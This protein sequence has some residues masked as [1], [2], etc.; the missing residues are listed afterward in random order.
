MHLSL[1]NGPDNAFFDPDAEDGLSETARRFVAGVLEHAPALVALTSATANS[2][3]RLRPQI[4]ASAFVCWGFG[5]R[6]ALVRIPV[7]QP[8]DGGKTTRIEFRA[9]DNT[10]NPY[11]ALLGILAAGEDGIDRRL[12]PPDPVGVDPGNLSAD[13]RAE[14]GIERLPR[15]LGAALDALEADAVLEEALGTELHEAYLEVKRGHW[16]QFTESAVGWEIDRLRSVY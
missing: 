15:T 7:P 4:G 3:A 11:L 10:A 1:W 12:S 14:R 5:N 6:E 16:E 8:N 9:A 13:A 2:Y